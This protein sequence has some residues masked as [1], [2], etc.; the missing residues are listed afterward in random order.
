MST[1]WKLR[2][3]ALQDKYSKMT[4]K[5]NG[6]KDLKMENSGLQQRLVLS[7]LEKSEKVENEYSDLKGEMMDLKKE[8]DELKR[9]SRSVQK[10]LSFTNVDIQMLESKGNSMQLKTD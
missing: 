7:N 8:N 2:V 4:K 9:Q 6:V 5:L 1:E 10:C 3:K